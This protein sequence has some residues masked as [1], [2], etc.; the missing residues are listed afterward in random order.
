MDGE[1]K[2]EAYR[3]NGD[4]AWV[5]FCITLGISFTILKCIGM[6]AFPWWLVLLPIWLPLVMLGLGYIVF[7]LAI[8]YIYLIVHFATM[9]DEKEEDA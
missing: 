4:A 5:A 6:L 3:E 1:K 8:G 7:F 2:P 9:K